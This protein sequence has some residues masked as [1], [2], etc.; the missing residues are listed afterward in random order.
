M[1]YSLYRER[2]KREK[3]PHDPQNVVAVEGRVCGEDA[4][5]LDVG[6]D[7]CRDVNQRGVLDV[8]EMV[9]TAF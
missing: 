8:D 9:C 7:E 4:L 2:S 6:K 1:P 3:L 5:I